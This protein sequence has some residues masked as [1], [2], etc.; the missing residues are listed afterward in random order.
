MG[1]IDFSSAQNY[2]SKLENRSERER[3]LS[4]FLT[5]PY[6]RINDSPS[7]KHYT[8]WNRLEALNLEI[9]DINAKEPS[10]PI[11][12]QEYKILTIPQ[13]TKLDGFIKIEDKPEN[14][15]I[16]A[17]EHKLVSLV[18]A[19]SK[20]TIIDLSAI[21]P[22]KLLIYHNSSSN[23]LIPANIELKIPEGENVD[24][25]YFSETDDQN[26]MTS[27]LISF[28]VPQN[29][30]LNLSII[31]LSA[32]SF[33]YTKGLVKGTINANIFSSKTK[34]THIDY[35]VDL[36]EKAQ[37]TFSS[38][39]IGIEDNNVDIRVAVNHLGVQSR[40]EGT[41]RG[42]STDSSLVIV[43][44]NAIIS[45]SGIDSSTSI[46][47]KAYTIGKDSKAIVAPMLEVKTGKVQ[48][49]KHSASISKVPEDLIFYLESR[50]FSRK[51]A[52][53]LIIK[54]FM[55]DENDP[56]FLVDLINEI[57]TERKILVSV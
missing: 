48:M 40:S 38:R 44:G 46:I 45:E 22:R 57:L 30:T 39:A 34:L 12:D 53:S 13:P 47:G 50:G 29:S 3:L 41:L 42:I 9:K 27:S 2:I 25:V 19:L 51:E 23:S 4:Q 11:L 26:S 18:L 33:I 21:T 1:L 49:A 36:D 28:V 7:L 5:M 52:E 31:S 15:L 55:I 14:A 32:H 24:V 56:K 35:Y 6:Q 37:S 54:G 43:R 16:K 20:K 10:K 17:D 8:D